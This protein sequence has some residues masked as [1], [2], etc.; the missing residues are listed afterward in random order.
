[1]QIKGKKSAQ[2]DQGSI[3]T[4]GLLENGVSVLEVV[5]RTEGKSWM[6]GPF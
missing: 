5:A 3:F 2:I 4:L 6:Q 1:M